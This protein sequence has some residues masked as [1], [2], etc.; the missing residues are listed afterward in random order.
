[1]LGYLPLALSH[2]ASFVRDFTQ[3]CREYLVRFRE[4]KASAVKTMPKGGEW[5]PRDD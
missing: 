1:M 5:D 2:V 4:F 3:G